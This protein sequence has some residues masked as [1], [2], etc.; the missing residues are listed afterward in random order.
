MNVIQWLRGKKTYG[1]AAGFIVVF[2]LSL[3]GVLPSGTLP[4]WLTPVLSVLAGLG[5]ACSRAGIAKAQQAAEDS[6]V[7]YKATWAAVQAFRAG[8]TAQ[9]LADATNAVQAGV[10]VVGD[11]SDVVAEAK[12]SGAQP[13]G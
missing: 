7:A 13:N 10:K 3:A 6:L 9:G 1:V 4:P 2:I 11:V 12:A 8:N 5:L